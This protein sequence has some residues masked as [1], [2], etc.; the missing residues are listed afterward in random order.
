MSIVPW[1]TD[2]EFMQLP[3]KDR[4]LLI[5][6]TQEAAYGGKNLETVK[7][8]WGPIVKQYLK[9]VGINFPAPWCAA[10]VTW[11]YGKAYEAEY[12]V[13]R[14]TDKELALARKWLTWRPVK[15]PARGL[16]GGW[17][18]KDGTGHVFFITKVEKVGPLTFVHTIEGNTNMEG[19]REGI[20]I[21]RRRRLVTPKMRFADGEQCARAHMLVDA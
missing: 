14:I 8:N 16:L 1:Y 17:V 11:C 3:L 20:G 13:I 18:N 10:F 12:R 15:E 7:A 5:A 19:S 2:E 6:A 21:F 9:S 4:A